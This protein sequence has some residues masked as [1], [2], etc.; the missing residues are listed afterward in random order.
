MFPLHLPHLH[1]LALLLLSL[2][3]SSPS[4]AAAE[5]AFMREGKEKRQ[6]PRK[7]KKPLKL[8]AKEQMAIEMED[9]HAC[10]LKD[11]GREVG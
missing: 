6:P 1:L 5:P 3:L 2:S 8:P 7:R 11:C 9:M 4:S 10:K